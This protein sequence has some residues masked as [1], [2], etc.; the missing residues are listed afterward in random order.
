[1]PKRIS[2][3]R[4]NQRRPTFIAQ[5]REHRGL[6]QEQLADRLETSKASIS[7][8]ENSEQP[9]TQD[10]L[11]AC[12]EALNTDPASLLMRDPTSEEP[13]WSIWDQAKP[14]E[15]KM[16]IEIARTVTKTGTDR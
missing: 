10:F 1:M 12:A 8:I 9:Y 14:G 5:W 6:T 7:R 4:P 11:E 2:Y 16:I 13:I 15:R 3:Q